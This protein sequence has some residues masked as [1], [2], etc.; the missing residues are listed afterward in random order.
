M[1]GKMGG[2][3]AGLPEGGG[4]EPSETSAFPLGPYPGAV[5]DLRS[6]LAGAAPILCILMNMLLN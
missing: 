1:V 3:A 5:C 4:V 6:G 2:G